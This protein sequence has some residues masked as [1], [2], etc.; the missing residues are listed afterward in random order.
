M[1]FDKILIS[2]GRKPITDHLG[3]ENTDIKIDARGFIEVNENGET[4]VP[5]IFA[6]GDVAGNPMLAHKATFEG[7]QVAD[8]IA[9]KSRKIETRIIPAVVFT[10][11]EI[12]WCG[13]TE[14][15]AKAE[16]RNV[17]VCRFPWSASGRALTMGAGNGLTRLILDE[18]TSK[19]LGVGIT[20]KGAGE[21]IGEGLLAVQQGLKAE[22][23]A[24]TV[25]PHPTLSE[26]MM[27]AADIFLGSAIHVYRK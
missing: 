22:E 19:I 2:I 6:V 17:K 12:A 16:K 20:G 27:E 11:P 9:G 25:H 13:I 23:L 26:T 8:F 14:Q 3:L 21:L 4:A 5:T 18:D 1:P 24:S 7:I 15:E 10:T